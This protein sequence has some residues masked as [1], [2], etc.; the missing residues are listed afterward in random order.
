VYGSGPEV[1]KYFVRATRDTNDTKLDDGD[2]PLIQR[3][4]IVA[5]L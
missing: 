5:A 2:M 4:R 1:Q 3:D